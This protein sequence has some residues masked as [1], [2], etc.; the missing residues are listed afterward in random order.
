[1][2]RI[3]RACIGLLKHLETCE[4]VDERLEEFKELV[5][6]CSLEAVYGPVIWKKIEEIRLTK[7]N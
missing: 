2:I 7:K 3:E 4:D 1:M 6:R 5:Y